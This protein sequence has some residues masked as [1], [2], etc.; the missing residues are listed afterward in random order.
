MSMSN[1]RLLRTATALV[2]SL[3]AVGCGWGGP[4]TSVAAPRSVEGIEAKREI[5]SRVAGDSPNFAQL[6]NGSMM[7][8]VSRDYGRGAKA[9]ALVELYYPNFSTD[10]L[11]DSYVGVEANGRRRWAHDMALVG[12]SIVPDT[13]LVRSAFRGDGVEL[14]I[15]D[16]MAPGTNVHLRRA[17]LTNRSGAAIANPALNFHGFFTLNTLPGGDRVRYDATSGAMLQQDGKIAVAVV[18]DR[19]PDAFQCGLAHLP[20]TNKR[21]ARHAAESGQ[22]PRAT[23]AGPS[24][25][26]VT[27]GMRQALKDLAPGASATATWAIALGNDESQALAVAQNALKGGWEAMKRQDAEHWAAWLA[28]GRIPAGMP[29]EAIKAYRRALIALKQL[30]ADNGALIAAPTNM[31]PPY[32]FVWLR[33]GALIAQALLEA[34]YPE[35]AKNFYRFAEKLQKPDG[36]WAV[37]YFPDA[38]RALWDF[39]TAGNEHDQPGFFAW[40]IQDVYSKTQD[41]T[42]LAAR[43][44]AVKKAC[45]FL[46]GQQR[47]DGLLT[48]CRDL[49]ELDTDGTWTFTNA[50]GWAG[51]NAGV[52]IAK[53][54]GD[55]ESVRRYGAAA[56]KLK[57]AIGDKLVVDGYF[58]RGLRTKGL[59]STVEAA[60]LALG[61]GGF[62]MLP[63]SDPR[64]AE[65]GRQVTNRLTAG[66]G[67]IRR[68]EGDRYYDGQP[69][70]VATSWLALHRLELGDR[71]TARRLFDSMTRYAAQTDSYMLGEQFDERTKQ[72]VSAFPLAWSEAMYVRTA[73]GVFG[74]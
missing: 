22:W 48:N 27:M 62:G 73:L 3:A 52:A 8:V 34:G 18:P 60:N 33:D 71:T 49:W 63:D 47:P 11:W 46:V 31:N 57:A 15:E 29:P 74:K 54:L 64:M 19:A 72:W 40:G 38:S 69:W 28:Q 41:R 12:Q 70:P 32:R 50:A 23:E 68:Y 55:A 1:H 21:D 58:S 36:G 25:G 30:A 24:V 10:H 5:I 2:A 44:P 6:S 17:T 45:E 67:G 16:V 61:G 4:Q 65:T 26:G 42:W 20:G 59:D 13:G 39:G 35:P 14:V 43:W 56:D 66:W 37:N 7:T 53:E 51:L 9:G